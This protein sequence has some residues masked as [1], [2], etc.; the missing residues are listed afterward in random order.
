MDQKKVQ[1][2]GVFKVQKKRILIRFSHLC[3]LDHVFRIR[4]AECRGSR[5]RTGRLV[6]VE[7]LTVVL[8]ASKAYCMVVKP[9]VNA[10][11]LLGCWRNISIVM[12]VKKVVIKMY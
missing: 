11:Q 9:V 4:E 3:I 10:G 1:R 7:S 12:H 6:H 8:F 2:Q 5:K